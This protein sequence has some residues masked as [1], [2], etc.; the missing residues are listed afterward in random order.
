MKL[1]S[2]ES[3]LWDELYISLIVSG[4]Q[5]VEAL[6]TCDDAIL[7]R[8]HH[9]PDIEKWVSDSEASEFVVTHVAGVKRTR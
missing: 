4:K 2:D 7:A 8:R 9:R 6:A 5:P 1:C 3:R